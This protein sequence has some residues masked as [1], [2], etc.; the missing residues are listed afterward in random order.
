MTVTETLERLQGVT[1]T[2]QN[3]WMARCPAHEDKR[4]SLAVSVSEDGSMILL[5]CHAGCATPDVCAAMGLQAQDLFATTMNSK[6]PASY[7]TSA[8]STKKTHAT[9]EAAT[10]A[11]LWGVNQISGQEAFKLVSAWSYSDANGLDVARVLRFEGLSGRKSKVFRPIHKNGSGWLTG[12]PPGAWPLYKLPGIINSNGLVYICEGEGKT[13]AA[14]SIGLNATCSAH[15]AKS[16]KKTDWTPL[17][18]RN[19]CIM[20]DNDNAGCLYADAVAGILTA[21][22]PPASVRVL[23]LP[24]LSE[25]EDIA[26]YI[27]KRKDTP[28]GIIREEIERLAN[29]APIWKLPEDATGE[30]FFILPGQQKDI[31]EAA[32]DIFSVI[33]P[34][35]TLFRRGKCIVELTEPEESTYE[36]DIVTPSAFRSRIEQYGRKIV[37]YRSDSKGRE[38]LKPTTCPEQTAKGLMDTKEAKKLL[39]PIKSVINAPVLIE[40][41]GKLLTLGKGYHAHNGGL[42]ITN[43]AIVPDV[44]IDEAL[45]SLKELLA[46]FDFQSE[47]DYSRAIASLITPA[48]RMGGLI[49]EDIPIDI[50]EAK[51]SQ[52]GKTYRQKLVCAIYNESPHT[53]T[54][55]TKGVGSLDE[56][57]SSALIAGKPFIA[58]DNMRGRVDSQILESALRGSGKVPARVPHKGEIQVDV[59]NFIFQLTSN[60]IEATKDLANRSCVVRIHKKPADFMFKAWPEGDLLAHVWAKQTYYLGCVFAVVRVWHSNGKLRT[61]ENRHDFRQWVQTLDWI[62]RGLFE[63]TPIMDGH[64]QAQDRIASPALTWLRSVAMA[65]DSEGKLSE[66]I[67]ASGLYELS[68][69]HGIDLPGLREESNETTARQHIG[70]MMARLFKATEAVEIDGYTV[71]RVEREEYFSEARQYQKMKFYS[72]NKVKQF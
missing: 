34:T 69:E 32:H 15:G 20:P 12:D 66:E 9:P 64:R 56:S 5:H 31:S 63:L 19:I 33:A 50:A 43:G 53:I 49:T 48:L 18:G 29:D 24:G 59:R 25:A 35:N 10:N 21:L 58:F 67:S 3:Q 6:P 4:S 65:A 45:E 7:S 27:E 23:A 51:E 62:A 70:R 37:A 1:K 72:I 39:P 14:C 60:G 57:I 42:L 13:D 41:N 30:K 17:A 22:E 47:G 38:T 40:S 16:A 28:P 8:R 46:D 71:T 54:Q 11:A 55:R 2:G 61:D 68:Q 26:D 44:E 36:L 52:S